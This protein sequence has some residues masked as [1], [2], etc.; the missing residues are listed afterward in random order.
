MILQK[1]VSQNATNRDQVRPTATKMTFKEFYRKLSPY[2][3]GTYKSAPD[4]VDGIFIKS[5]STNDDGKGITATSE[6]C[7][8]REKQRIVQDERAF[9]RFSRKYAPSFDVELCTDVLDE[10]IPDPSLEKLAGDFE[11]DVP[12]INFSNCSEKL[13]YL[14]KGIL[15]DAAERSPGSKA[16]KE[17]I[18]RQRL[19]DESH[20][21]CPL[22]H[23][24]ITMIQGKQNSL[25]PL[26]IDQSGEMAF[27]NCLASCPDCYRSFEGKDEREK[28]QRIKDALA[29][30]EGEED[31]INESLEKAVGL[32]G[33]LRGDEPVMLEYQGVKVEQKIPPKKNTYFYK[34]VLENVTRYFPALRSAFQ[35]E[36][37][38]DGWSFQGLAEFMRRN[39]LAIASKETDQEK[40]FD[41]LVQI[42]M[43]KAGCQRT[44]AEIIV[45]YFVQDCEVFHEISQ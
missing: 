13:A 10:V 32:L 29:N 14:L 26:L 39:Y 6:K 1:Q 12:G 5:A 7:S 30:E 17:N 4:F 18:L 23:K 21:E 38:K 33:K 45:S 36:E 43:E 2:L 25:T 11:S 44:P 22:C 40:I 31:S 19:N 9:A 24:E 34:K 41:G 42:V 15:E 37:G 8:K 28:L 20:G 16:Q 27:E 35:A 3:K